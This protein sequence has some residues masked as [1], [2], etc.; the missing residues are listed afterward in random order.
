MVDFFERL[1]TIVM[2]RVHDF[3]GINLVAV[4]EGGTLNIGF[5]EQFVFP[6]INP[7]ESPF[8]FPLG[9]NVVSKVR[10]RDAAIETYRTL[11]VPLK[12][13]GDAEEGKTKRRKK[14]K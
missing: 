10:N 3:R 2:P 4:D 14:T 11:G 7:E 6:E 1:I 12:K 5:R 8:T 13:E 9:V